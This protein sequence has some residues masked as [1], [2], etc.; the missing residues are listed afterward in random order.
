M[1]LAYI[2]EKIIPGGNST[3][4][5]P[6]AGMCLTCAHDTLCEHGEHGRAAGTESEG[7]EARP[8]RPQRPQ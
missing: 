3:C 8:V 4:H 5:G 1:T 2:Q 7:E 6:E